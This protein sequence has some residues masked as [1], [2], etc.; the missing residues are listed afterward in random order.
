[1]HD[2]NWTGDIAFHFKGAIISLVVL[3]YD[4]TVYHLNLSHELSRSWPYRINTANI[5][6]LDE[7]N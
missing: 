2:S 6:E 1:M 7:E 5:D 4:R 3:Y